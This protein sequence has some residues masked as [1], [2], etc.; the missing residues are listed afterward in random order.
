MPVAVAPVDRQ[1]DFLLQGRDQLAALA[2]DG[3]ASAEVVIVFGHGQKP[4][5]RD[6]AASQ[7]A[8]Q[9]WDHFRDGLGPAERNNQNGIVVHLHRMPC[10]AR[11]DRA[12][13]PLSQ[14]PCAKIGTSG[15]KPM[16]P[17]LTLSLLLLPPLAISQ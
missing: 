6:V 1:R 9:K 7:H 17:C 5:A 12:P 8:L 11:S 4:L 13:Q 15:M 3:A 2:V 10:G 14:P 16:K